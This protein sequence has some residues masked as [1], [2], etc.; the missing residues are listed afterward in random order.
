MVVTW[1]GALIRAGQLRRWGWF[2][3]LLVLQLLGLGIAGMIASA[4]AGPEGEEIVYRP[5]TT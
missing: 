3:A 2:V 5:T 1:I 4:A